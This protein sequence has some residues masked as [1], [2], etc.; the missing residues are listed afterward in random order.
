L[1]T[2]VKTKIIEKPDFNG[3][4]AKRAQFTV[5]QVN[6]ANRRERTFELSRLHIS[7]IYEELKKG[8]TILEI[9]RRGSA[10]DTRYFV[11]PIR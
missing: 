3:K 11:K 1:H 6:D 5:I 8:K 2:I 9:S 10:K 4:I 7:K